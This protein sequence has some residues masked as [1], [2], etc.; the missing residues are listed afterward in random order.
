M[1]LSKISSNCKIRHYLE[2]EET[3]WCYIGYFPA[4]GTFAS[5]RDR[6]N[7][8]MSTGE[9]VL[10]VSWSIRLD[11]PS[12]PEAVFN[13]RDNNWPCAGKKNRS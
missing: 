4:I 7:R 13:L 10:A 12:G 9:I 1:I 5:L 8:S 2:T 6:L 11:T 3:E